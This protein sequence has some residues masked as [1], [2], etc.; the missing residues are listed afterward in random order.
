MI[1]SSPLEFF[2][3]EGLKYLV[4][5]WSAKRRLKIIYS[6]RNVMKRDENPAAKTKK[7]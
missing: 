5:V 1:S 4:V 3:E 2:C 6:K 7:T